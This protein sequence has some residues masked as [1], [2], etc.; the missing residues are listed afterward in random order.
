M[1]APTAVPPLSVLV[2]M[3][4]LGESRLEAIH[5]FLLE[6]P[7]GQV[8]QSNESNGKLQ[9]LQQQQQPSIDRHTF[10]RSE[11]ENQRRIGMNAMGSHGDFNPD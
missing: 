3:S 8:C 11:F 10:E 1:N 5:S 9:L 6:F 4:V 2:L 7:I